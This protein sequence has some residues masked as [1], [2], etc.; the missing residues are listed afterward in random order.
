MALSAGAEASMAPDGAG[1]NSPQE[2]QQLRLQLAESERNQQETKATVIALRGEFMR[3]V[4][5]WSGG[6]A[7]PPGSDAVAVADP[8]PQRPGG[9]TSLPGTPH[10]ARRSAREAAEALRA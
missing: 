10:G 7:G 2:V 5:M 1:D 4:Q 3:L 9:R 8:K 6:D